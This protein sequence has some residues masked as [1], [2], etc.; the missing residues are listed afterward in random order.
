MPQHIPGTLYPFKSDAAW[1]RYPTTIYCTSN[2]T[3][4]QHLR[5][6]QGTRPRFFVFL[7]ADPDR[8][9]NIFAMPVTST[10]TAFGIPSGQPAHGY[11][12][13]SELWSIPQIVFT[14]YESGHSGPQPYI[15]SCVSQQQLQQLVG[16][17]NNIKS[18][19]RPI[20]RFTGRLLSR[21]V[22]RPSPRCTAYGYRRQSQK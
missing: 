9:G 12:K 20:G 6:G 4:K 19:L 22:T 18:Q 21:P 8:P 2:S 15:Y 16:I 13:N 17:S 14:N 11:V 7:G 1:A 3:T 10:V 5:T